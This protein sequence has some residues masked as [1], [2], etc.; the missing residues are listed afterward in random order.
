L[1]NSITPENSEAQENG[2]ARLSDD[3]SQKVSSTVMSVY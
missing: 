3:I 1:R 2:A